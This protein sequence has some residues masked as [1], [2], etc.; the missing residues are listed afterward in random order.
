MANYWTE[1]RRE[2]YCDLKATTIEELLAAINRNIL[3]TQKILLDAIDA[4]DLTDT[5]AFY[6]N[7]IEGILLDLREDLMNIMN[8]E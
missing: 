7:M 3:N 1:D 5:D 4:D 2:R 8:K 6:C